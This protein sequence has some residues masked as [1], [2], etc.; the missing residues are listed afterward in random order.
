MMSNEL[1]VQELKRDILRYKKACRSALSRPI[2]CTNLMDAQ[3][4]LRALNKG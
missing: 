1:K 4:A 3:Y 2:D